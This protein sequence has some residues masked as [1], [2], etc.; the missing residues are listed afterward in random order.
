MT[1]EVTGTWLA[2]IATNNCAIADPAPAASS[3]GAAA[4]PGVS[5]SVRTGSRNRAASP[6]KRVAVLNPAG[7]VRS[8]VCAT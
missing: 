5:I 2:A 8:P 3:A 4:A 7:V 1:T 6:S